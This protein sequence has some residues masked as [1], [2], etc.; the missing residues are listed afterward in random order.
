M[1]SMKRQAGLSFLSI[2][3]IAIMVGFF[4]MS[5]IRMAPSYM[6][7]LTIKDVVGAIATEPG[8][9]EHSVAAI[10]RRLETNFNT[11]QIYGLRARDIE[12]YRE[13]GETYIDANYE[14]RIPLVGNI[15][16]VMKFEDL[17]FIAGQA[18][19]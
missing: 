19:Q 11:N 2:L 15:D 3:L 4:V 8:A 18:V 13:N 6:E 17:E 5:G 9:K 7:Y 12:V 16:A 10:R 1:K 14:A